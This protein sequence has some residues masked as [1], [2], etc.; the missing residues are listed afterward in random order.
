MPHIAI[1][2]YVELAAMTIDG[3]L[4]AVSGNADWQSLQ[5]IRVPFDP[6]P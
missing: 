3:E 2:F 5:A 4:D 1:S 6:R